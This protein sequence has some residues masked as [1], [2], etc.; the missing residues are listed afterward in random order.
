MA[1]GTTA[2]R[3]PWSTWVVR[4]C[5]G[6]DPQSTRAV[7]EMV[8]RK[9][10]QHAPIREGDTMLDVGTGTGL[11]GFGALPLVGESGAV[12]FNDIS[13]DLLDHCRTTA[14]EMGALDR[15]RFLQAPADDLS[16]L[17]EGSVDV[18]ALKAVLIFVREKRRAFREFH[19]VLRP[20]GRLYVEEPINRFGSPEPDSQFW[21]YEVGPIQDL[22][23]RVRSVFER[24]QPT[25]TDPMLDFD[26][27]DLLALAEEAGFTTVELEYRASVQGRSLVGTRIGWEETWRGR[28]NP[29]SPS[30]EEAVAE[31]LSPEEAQR[32]VGYL[33]P[34]V[35]GEPRVMRSARAYLWAVK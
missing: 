32:F 24:A 3:E 2:E 27:R 1:N 11:I 26:E 13:G 14:G 8:L 17:A 18:V 19:R 35:E 34:K 33:R 6:R 5:G 31:A 25:E 21:G 4:N 16:S 28:G 30:L 9:V 10:L 15:C 29:R 20:E 12:I 7:Q 22:A 23:A